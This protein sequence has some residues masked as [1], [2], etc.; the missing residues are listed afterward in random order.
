[1]KRGR[2]PWRL[3]GDA[4][5]G[6][7]PGFGAAEVLARDFDPQ[8]RTL[9]YARGALGQQIFTG[10]GQRDRVASNAL[11]L[12]FEDRPGGNRPVPHNPRFDDPAV[13]DQS[14]AGLADP[15]L[16]RAIQASG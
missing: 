2:L 7:F 15:A 9:G 11:K 16:D 6:P 12:C 10:V 3:L 8:F 5:K 4:G 13:L 14:G 1:M